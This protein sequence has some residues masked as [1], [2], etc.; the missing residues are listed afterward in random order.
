MWSP[1]F[2]PP[3]QF[4]E[5]NPQPPSPW[6]ALPKKVVVVVVGIIRMD[7]DWGV[8]APVDSL[9]A[10]WDPG[11][12]PQYLGGQQQ[13][14]QQQQQ[15]VICALLKR[16]SDEPVEPCCPVCLRDLHSR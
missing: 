10:G 12:P 16:H 3:I 7:L 1:S 11:A 15:Q 4:T 5:N 9:A 13:Q 14:Q 8:G 6:G 2:P